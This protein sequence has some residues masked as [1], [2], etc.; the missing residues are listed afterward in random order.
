MPYKCVD[1]Y[2]FSHVSANDPA[3]VLSRS[4]DSFSS[5]SSLSG[6]FTALKM[7]LLVKLSAAVGTDLKLIIHR[8]R[9]HSW[10]SFEKRTEVASP[11]YMRF[12]LTNGSLHLSVISNSVV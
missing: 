11:T 6:N 10:Y 7:V 3:H 12:H 2:M 4:L 1:T 8:Q 5:G 9:D